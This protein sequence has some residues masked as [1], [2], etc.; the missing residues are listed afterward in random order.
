MPYCPKCDM[1]FIDGI[2]VCSDCG[3]ALVSS[4][5]AADAVKKQEEEEALLRRQAEY[6]ARQAELE[7]AQEDLETPPSE[8]PNI[9]PR[10]YVKKAQQY[11]DLKSSASAFFLVGGIL[12]VFSALCWANVVR[13]PLAG[14]SRMISQTVMTVLG[15]ASIVVAV[16]SARSAKTVS[17]QIAD[18]EN[19]TR[20]L[21]DWFAASYTGEQLD[22]QILAESGELAPEELSLKRFELIQ[23][24]L[25]TSHDISDQAYADLIAE[26]IYENLY[27]D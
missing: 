19:A 3:G 7:A 14:T 23:D 22:E 5:E 2:T 4:K 10:V 13:L 9:R 24:I 6:E 25:I 21:K 8:R 20:E 26:D 27:Q 18:E 17:G 11:E 1:E 15:I 12:I 16:H